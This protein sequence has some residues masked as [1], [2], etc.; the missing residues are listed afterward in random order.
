LLDDKL[1]IW[2]QVLTGIQSKAN[3]VPLSAT[4]WEKTMEQHLLILLE[5]L[6]R[7][8]RGHDS[9]ETQ[10][11]HRLLNLERDTAELIR[12]LVLCSQRKRVL[13]IGTS[14]GYSAI[15]LAS[16]LLEIRGSSSL[17][18]IERD[19]AKA[20]MAKQNFKRAN[21]EGSIDLRVGSATDIV[22]ELNGPFDCIFFDAD[23]VSAPEQL[24][25]LVPKLTDD[26]LLLAD[27]VLSHPQEIEGYIRMF[28]QLP[29]FTTSVVRIGK[30]LHVAHRSRN[31]GNS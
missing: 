8:G 19:S 12:M 16:T 14:N 26:V 2:R 24:Q 6:E 28:D 25:L 9:Q 13:E 3:D 31:S 7:F 18:T 1:F 23:R 15:Y 22:K 21:L 5:E 20:L 29:D 10:H 4:T 30:G 27:N 11:S 17:I